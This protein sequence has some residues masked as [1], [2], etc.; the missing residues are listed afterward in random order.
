M[1]STVAQAKKAF[2]TELWDDN[3]IFRQ[4]LGICSSLAVTNLMFNTLLMC[5]GLVWATAMTSLTVSALRRYTPQRVRMIV[6]VLLAAVYVIVV[7]IVFRAQFPDIHRVIGPYVGLIIT[8]CIIMGRA[9]AFASKNP[10]LPSLL[11][12]IGA[13]LGY[14]GILMTVA[15]L[16]EVLGFGSVFGVALPGRAV[17]WQSWTI[18]VMPPGAF[19]VLALMVWAARAH[20]LRLD[21]ARKAKEAKK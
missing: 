14:S 7:D 1:A 18:M 10:V 4:V 20:A 19:F 6:Q 16:R 2:V 13:G 8:N 21:A 5:L 3:P 11:D 9:E 12:G 17:W 15:L